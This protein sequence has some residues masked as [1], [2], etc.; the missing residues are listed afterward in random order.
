MGV[1]ADDQVDIRYGFC[2]NFIFGIAF[3]GAGTAVGDAD[4]HVHVFV[5]PDMPDRIGGSAGDIPE[6]Q[7]AGRR[8]GKGIFSEDAQYS[9]FYLSLCQHD[10]VFHAVSFEGILQKLLVRGESVG[11]HGFPVNIAQNQGRQRVFAFDS[12]IQGA[13]QAGGAVIEFVISQGGGVKTHGAQHPEFC[14]VRVE[15]GL[16]QC[17]HG[18]ISGIQQQRIRVLRFCLVDQGLNSGKAAQGNILAVFHREEAVQV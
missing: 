12:S 10:I 2:Q 3:I 6:F 7:H 1:A 11:F 14:G 4:D 16:Y 13:G 5:F 8:A 17:S 9:D 18:E 15:N